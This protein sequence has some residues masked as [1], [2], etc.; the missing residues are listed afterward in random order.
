MS[1]FN[2]L[3]TLF[4]WVYYMINP[5]LLSLPFVIY[6]FSYELMSYRR[7]TSYMLVYIFIIIVF[8]QTLMLT[9]VTDQ[10]WIKYFFYSS[11]PGVY[12][13]ATG[14]LFFLFIMI[15]LHE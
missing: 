15:F 3:V 10:I 9:N 11:T 6:I 12:N 1:N 7:L 14:Y 8:A 4:I 13:Y 5:C 2:F